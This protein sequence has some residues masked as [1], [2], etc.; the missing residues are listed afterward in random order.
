MSAE[1]R[2]LIRVTAD[3]QLV[4]EG[5]LVTLG[6][7]LVSSELLTTRQY[8]SIRNVHNQQEIRAADLVEFIQN[9]VQQ[10]PQCYHTFIAVLE[11]DR[12]QYGD[13]LE[14][15]G[16]TYNLFHK[17]TTSTIMATP[18]DITGTR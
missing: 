1:Y 5:Q 10:N 17:Q 13:I 6:A 8:R 15:L 2:T 18:S 4:V 16:Q 14:T 3:L 7:K 9:K 12:S 11:Q